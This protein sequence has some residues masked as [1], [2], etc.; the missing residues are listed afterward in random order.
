ML[1]IVF[2]LRAGRRA[3][4]T[5]LDWH[6]ERVRARVSVG[7]RVFLFVTAREVADLSSPVFTVSRSRSRRNLGATAKCRRYV[8]ARAANAH[9][10][11]NEDAN[12]TKTCERARRISS[13]P[14]RRS[15][16]LEH[17]DVYA[18]RAAR[19]IW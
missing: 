14:V 2:R 18:L 6:A 16:G 17:T 13:K 8:C 15:R 4:S 3:E 19:P 11:V 5:N 10:P 12:K 1:L 7:G 9:V